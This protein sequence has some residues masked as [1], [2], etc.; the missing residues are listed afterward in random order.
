MAEIKNIND[1][2]DIGGYSLHVNCYGEGGQTV[3]FE[4]GL[5]HGSEDWTLVQP[6][7]SKIARTFS[8]DRAGIGNSDKT[9]ARRT[10]FV[11]VRALHTLLDKAKV[12][13]P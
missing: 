3:I 2:I 11:Q 12:K 1:R 5:G 7:I 4:S 10:S 6:E 8:Y 13:F 9:K